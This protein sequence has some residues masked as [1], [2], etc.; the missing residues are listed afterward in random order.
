MCAVGLRDGS[1]A[2]HE[3]GMQRVRVGAGD[4]GVVGVRESG[5]KQVA[6]GTAALV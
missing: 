2:V 1:D 6:I 4:V 3:V 5:G